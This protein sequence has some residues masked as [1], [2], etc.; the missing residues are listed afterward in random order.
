LNEINARAQKQNSD[1]P[2]DFGPIRQRNRDQH[3]T[4]VMRVNVRPHTPRPKNEHADSRRR[5][6]TVDIALLASRHRACSP[7]RENGN[8][9]E[10]H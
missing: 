8:S 10:R 4:R 6:H 1:Q 2:D 3:A 9:L 7:E 5:S